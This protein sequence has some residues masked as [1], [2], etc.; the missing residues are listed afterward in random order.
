[1]NNAQ[2]NIST[3]VSIEQYNLLKRSNEAQS[4]EIAYL[5]HRIAE[6]ERMIFG[7]RSE[8]FV[9]AE[10]PGQLTLGL[11]LPEASIDEA[12]SETITYQRK[13]QEEKEIKGHGR[14]ALPAHL[15]RHEEIIEPDDKPEGS[16]KIGEEV[17]EVL[18]Y[19]QGRMWVKRTI[20]P[21]YA[22]PDGE[23][24]IIAPVP[25][26]PIP[27]GNAGASLLAH[28][29]VSKF[30]DHLP[31]Y[32]Q[33][34]QFRR[35]GVEIAESTM[36]DWVRRSCDLLAPLYGKLRDEIKQ[37]EY[38]QGDETPIP[39]LTEDKPGATHKGYLW[40]YHDPLK[41]LVLFD[42]YKGRDRAGPREILEDY[43]G[44]LQ[45]DG[46][47]V[48]DIYER[49]HHLHLIGCMAH[50]RRRFDHALDTDH[51]RSEYMLGKFAQLYHIEHKA[52]ESDMTFEQRKELREKEALPVLEEMETWL[53]GNMVHVLPRSAIGEAISYTLGQWKWLVRYMEDG[54]FEIDNNLIENTIRP[55]ALGR[56]NYLFAGS[57]EAAQRTAVI[58]SFLGCCKRNQVNP[59]EWLL[60]I[61]TRMPEHKANRLHELLPHNWQNLQ[62]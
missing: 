43:H 47:Q 35:D 6:F 52:R 18:E 48:Y 3:T 27:K 22:L 44:T 25:S 59:M 58:Y 9:P 57:H 36:T 33:I 41:R 4:A 17:S 31:L 16:K 5:K 24:V 8:R 14:I 45:T 26:Q 1:V 54:Q 19:T 10:L 21:K 37:A 12:T 49:D 62:K 50:A 29:L 56:K 42:Y 23:G 2:E 15:P 34:Q 28:I 11:D 32:R 20:R 51:A 38:L 46:Y 7:A 61:L 39:V 55:V 53:K 30:V 40:V 13:K 60:D